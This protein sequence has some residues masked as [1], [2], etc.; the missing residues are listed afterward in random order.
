MTYETGTADD[1][2]DLLSKLD[3]FAQTTHGGWSSIYGTNPL[4]A[5]GWFEL[6][7]GSGEDGISASMRYTVTG[8]REHVSLH[9]ATDPVDAA[10]APGFHTN[11]SGN[12]YNTS[13]LVSSQT[14]TTLRTE[15]CVSE[16]ADGPYVSYHFFAEDNGDGGDYIHVV[17]EVEP[18]MF[19]HFGFGRKIERFGDGWGGGSYCYGQYMDIGSN[20]TF[21]DARHQFGFDSFSNSNNRIRGGTIRV[22]SGLFNQGAVR[23][24][25]ANVNPSSS[26][27]TD[28]AGN[29]RAQIMASN[30]DGIE[31]RSSGG[32]SGS[33]ST[34]II[35]TSPIA[36]YWTDPVPTQSR[37]ARRQLLGYI[38][39]TRRLS[40]RNLEPGQEFSLGTETWI[41][42]PYSIRT[43]ATVNFRTFFAGVAYRK[44]V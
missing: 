43:E 32:I 31:I 24:G 26:L 12:G 14:S 19:R 33:V 29:A 30:R 44:V 5:N 41:A 28:T 35:P 8:E 36:L 34:G 2:E 22:S 27:L 20:N 21:T 37:G 39:G 3:T 4:T 15:R 9:H 13:S 38:P 42:F 7:K 23:Y 16:L 17:A 40:V 10:T 6:N 11:D 1:L 25:V 18:G